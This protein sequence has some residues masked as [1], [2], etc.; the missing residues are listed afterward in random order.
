MLAV[1]EVTE[2]K[3]LAAMTKKDYAELIVLGMD[4]KAQRTK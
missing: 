3:I 1:S 4:N 2:L